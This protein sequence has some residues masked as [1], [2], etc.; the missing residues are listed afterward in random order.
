MTEATRAPADQD[1]PVRLLPLDGA[2]GPDPSSLDLKEEELRE[3]YRLMALTR[4]ADLE[5][6][7]LQRQGQLAVYPPLIGQEAAQVGSAFALD[8][9]EWIFPSYRELGA[10]VVRGIDLVDYLEFYRG[11]WHGGGYD[12]AA[13]HFGMVSVPVASQTL[14]AV[15][16]GM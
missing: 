6:T 9:T 8:P 3:L 10:A 12:P 15:G 2:P 4:R 14:H 13:T 11:T 1:E 7:A 16:Y 5:A